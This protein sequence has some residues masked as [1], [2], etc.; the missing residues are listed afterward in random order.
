MV[1]HLERTRML[2]NSYQFIFLFLPVVF[3]GF[4]LIARNSHQL[5][6]LWLAGASLFFYGWWN[7][8]FITL[9]L[10]SIGFNFWMGSLIDNARIQSVK[11][12]RNLTAFAIIANLGLLGY[13]KYTNFFIATV[14]GVAGT[15][16]GLVD[17]VLP[18]GISFFTFTQIAFLV[19]VCRG[20]ARERNLIHYL[21]FVTYFPHLIAGPV[22]HHKQMMPQFAA[23]KTY[24]IS[25][26]NVAIGLT[27]FAFGLCKK[28][29]LADSIAP[30]ANGVFDAA[31]RGENIMLFD[32]W[33]GALAYT[34]QLYFDFSGYSD[35]AIGLSRLFNIRLPLNFNSP[36]QS[37]SVIEFWR[38]WHMTLSTFLRDYLYVPLGGNRAGPTRRYV[39]LM[40]TMLLGG[41]WHGANWTFVVWGGLHGVFLVINHLWR[42]LWQKAGLRRVGPAWLGRGLAWAVTFLSVVVTWVFFRAD[43]FGAANVMLAAMAGMHGATIGIAFEHAAWAQWIAHTFGVHFELLGFLP[44]ATGASGLSVAEAGMLLICACVIAWCMPNTQQVLADFEPA[45][46]A[47]KPASLRFV[48][49]WHSDSVYWRVSVGLLFGCA[50]FAINRQSTFLYFQF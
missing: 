32:A 19:D 30:I 39:N 17:L 7:P 11:K 23:K 41:L 44:L 26:D 6:A 18:L 13:F 31:Q 1:F 3:A 46:D 33:V 15:H 2:Y 10:A 14:N 8:V 50:I 9:L 12:A 28:V 36:Y 25:S 16:L 5:A 22:L 42:G 38:R 47:V 49:F 24:R 37:T 45:L 35:M 4:F 48:N 40:T 20:I 34:M 27:F 21:L 43:D 29:L